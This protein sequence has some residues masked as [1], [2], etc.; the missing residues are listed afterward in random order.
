M[1]HNEPAKQEIPNIAILEQ[2]IESALSELQLLDD[3]GDAV[4]GLRTKPPK[5]S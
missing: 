5:F 1:S 4:V 2:E 3:H